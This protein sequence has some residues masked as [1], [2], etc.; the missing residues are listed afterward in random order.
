MADNPGIASFR[1]T[2]GIVTDID[3]SDPRMEADVIVTAATVGFAASHIQDGR[4]IEFDRDPL[5]AAGTKTA[6]FEAAVTSIDQ[7][8]A[9]YLKKNYGN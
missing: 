4:P 3:T 9:D 6:A 2:R 8:I 1:R 5:D 7:A